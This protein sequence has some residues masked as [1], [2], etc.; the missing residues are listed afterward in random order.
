MKFDKDRLGADFRNILDWMI[1]K[2]YGPKIKARLESYQKLKDEFSTTPDP[3][4]ALKL[5]VETK[6]TNSYYRKP[7][8]NFETELDS[9]LEK[10]KRDFRT[11]LAMDEF[12][13]L[14]KTH[15]VFR[16]EEQKARDWVEKLLKGYPTLGDFS[17]ELYSLRKKGKNGLL[18][19][20][21]ADHYLRAV[22][23]WDIIPIDIHE[24]RFLLR[25]GIYHAFS[26]N[27]RQ[28][29]LQ[30]RSLQD[31]LNRFC[32]RYLRG[33]TVEGIDLYNAPGI[34]D[35]FI[36]SF[37]SD[38]RYKICGSRPICKGCELRNACLFGIINIQKEVAL[39]TQT[40]QG[41][42]ANKVSDKK[43]AWLS[44]SEARKFTIDKGLMKETEHIE[45]FRTISLQ[46]SNKLD[47]VRALYMKLFQWRGL[48]KEFTVYFWK[49]A[50]EDRG[51]KACRR[52]EQRAEEIRE[53]YPQTYDLLR[54]INK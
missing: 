24:K 53:C 4:G 31:A 42:E 6:V 23:Y 8:S 51:K 49:D 32:S 9:L 45:K 38:E 50:D 3:L 12:V 17:C 25:T 43:S 10:Y 18:R 44:V 13:T 47:Y 34:V 5:L 39:E 48:W 2:Q 22:G 37:C 15:S 40:D 30:D 20:K 28:D 14:I 41:P 46:Y 16:L 27:E 19:D 21:G 35:L 11:P 7:S 52:Y 54:G 36:W 29:P 33:K 1:E 26:G